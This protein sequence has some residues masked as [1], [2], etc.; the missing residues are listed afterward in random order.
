MA[1]AILSIPVGLYQIGRAHEFGSR[2]ADFKGYILAMADMSI[3]N[4]P[5]SR[6]FISNI[7]PSITWES[8]GRVAAIRYIRHLGQTQG[9]AMLLRLRNDYPNSQARV[10]AMWQIVVNSRLN[11][12]EGALARSLAPRF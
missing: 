9:S 12:R 8:R 10:N 6:R 3:G 11:A 1:V 7:Y 4:D 5:N 2:I